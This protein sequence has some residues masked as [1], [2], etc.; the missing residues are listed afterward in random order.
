M[1]QTKNR[2]ISL[3]TVLALACSAL[4]GAMPALAAKVDPQIEFRAVWVPTIYS[5]DYPSSPTTDAEALMDQADTIINQCKELGMTAIIL[6]VRPAADAFYESDIFPWSTYLTGKQGQAPSDGL[7]PL[8]Y[9][10]S[11]A[12]A[13]GLELHAWVNPFRVA[14]SQATYNALAANHPARQ[15]PEWV[16]QHDGKYYFDPGIPQV[17]DLIVRGVEEIV[18]KYSVDGIHMDDRFYPGTDFA[19]SASFSVY[20]GNFSSLA[21]WRRNNND[22]LVQRLNESVHALDADCRF[23]IGP[24]GIWANRSSAHPEGS[25]TRGYESYSQAYADTRKWVKEGWI[26]YIAPQLYWQIGYEIADYA[27]LAQW[28]ADTVRGTG[29]DLYIGMPDYR[30]GEDPIHWVGITNIM[31]Q[32]ELN[33]SIPEITGEVH[34][35]YVS[36]VNNPG[37]YGMYMRI[38]AG[39]EPPVEGEQDTQEDSSEDV[40]DEEESFMTPLLNLSNHTVY[41]SGSDGRFNAEEPLT[42]AQAA[43]IFSRL[44]VDANDEA[45]FDA[46]QTY[47]CNF[48]DVE[49]QAW[50]A[51]RVG[52]LAQF[53]VLQG[54][55]D[56]T[57]RPDAA[58]TRA[59]FV[60]MIAS[61]GYEEAPKASFSDLKETHWAA[62][63]IYNAAALGYIGGYPDGTFRPDESIT[64]AEAVI[65]IN[66]LLRRTPDKAYIDQN[67]ENPYADLKETHWAYH[68]IMEASCTHYFQRTET[69]EMWLSEP[70]E[71]LPIEYFRPT[72]DLSYVS[73]SFNFIVPEL[74]LTASL[75]PLDIQNVSAIAIHHMESATATFRDV[76]RWHVNGN[77]W[78]AIGYNFFIDFEGNVWV[79]RG[80]NV[81]AAVGG[82]NDF[83]VSIGFQGDYQNVNKN[84]PLA[85]YE[86]GINLLIWLLERLPNVQTVGGHG[87]YN[88][89]DCP[90][91]YFPLQQ[92]LV[93]YLNR[94]NGVEGG[95]TDHWQD[96]V[97]QG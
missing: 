8:A 88:D 43:T 5:L 6:Q 70:P 67:E 55:P 68:E 75:I 16:V 92:M 57:F 86:A 80:W 26:D 45:M 71:E 39:K 97:P 51:D 15:H 33:R 90:G 31:E 47:L 38:Y 36:V 41:L 2:I 48:T 94:M 20:G 91:R 56:G 78:R 58:M 10:I 23:G 18:R 69:G 40:P 89:T 24:A 27:H 77:G 7:D 62:K 50:Y 13:E 14:V 37:L 3:L 21:D 64:R 25:D 12:H 85:Q 76:E 93:D 28:W 82:K 54:Y 17:Q 72:G 74:T 60:T 4:A 53:G 81:G 1:K 95:D 65:V 34:Y 22:T 79:G 49:Q 11:R 83:T 44:L 42:R 73:N 61:F 96:D 29:V 59:E 35:R 30:A 46:Y 52:F 87:D 84:M 9:W 63:Y 32:C 19:D 66:R